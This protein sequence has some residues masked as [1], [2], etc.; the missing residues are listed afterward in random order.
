MFIL[1]Y[2]AV[3]SQLSGRVIIVIKHSGSRCELGSLV[4]SLAISVLDE[5]QDI[6]RLELLHFI[7][8]KLWESCLMVVIIGYGGR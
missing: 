3:I 5:L 7:R 6:P 4:I 8:R 1:L 2:L